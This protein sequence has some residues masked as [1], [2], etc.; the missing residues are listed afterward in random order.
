MAHVIRWQTPP[1][2]RRAP[3]KTK[4]QPPLPQL[5]RSQPGKWALIRE[6]APYQSYG[7]G[8][9]KTLGRGFEVKCEIVK[10]TRT[11]DTYARAVKK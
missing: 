4:P 8:L 2:E 5:L 6:G 7:G 1:S 9:R 3:R 10:G 11:W